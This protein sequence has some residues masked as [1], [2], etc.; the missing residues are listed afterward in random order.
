MQEKTENSFISTDIIVILIA[1]FA[2]IGIIVKAGRQ[3]NQEKKS[4]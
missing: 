4:K 3:G 1:L 2:V